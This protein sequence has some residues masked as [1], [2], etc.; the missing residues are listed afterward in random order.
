MYKRQK[1]IRAI[2]ENCHIKNI[3]RKTRN[4]LK[5]CLICQLVKT[6]NERKEGCL[7]YTSWCGA[8]KRTEAVI[9]P[10]NPLLLQS[11]GYGQEVKS[12]EEKKNFTII[13]NNYLK[14]IRKDLLEENEVNINNNDNEIIY[15]I[16]EIESI[17]V[18]IMIDTGAN[19]SIINHNEL[20][21]IQQECHKNLPIL[22]ILSLIHI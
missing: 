3:N 20:D 22:P 5:T 14:D 13:Y 4:Y 16:A 8:F 12:R 21:R 9:N 15:I 7:L 18:P 6:N 10:N 19:V 17:S 2:E 1:V 11:A